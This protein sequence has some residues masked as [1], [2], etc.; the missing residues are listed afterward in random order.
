VADFSIGEFHV[1]RVEEWS[2]ALGSPDRLFVGFEPSTWAAHEADFAPAFYADGV[3]RGFL[4]SWLIEAKGQLI[5]LDTGVGNGKTRPSLPFFSDLDSDFLASFAKTGFAP[6]EVDIVVNSHLHMDHVGWNT[7][8]DLKGW[9]PTFPN[10]RYLVPALDLNFWNPVHWNERR[11]RGAEF[12]REAFED[13][14]Q[15]VLDKGLAELIGDAYEIAPGLTLTATPGHTPG[16]MMMEAESGG[17]HALFV[18]DVVHHPIQIYQPNWSTV[19]CEDTQLAAETRRKVL[20][21]AADR[22]ARI[23]PAHFAGRHWVGI[24]RDGQ[25]FCP[26]YESESSAS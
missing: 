14:I 2:G 8:R 25:N 18:A 17:E 1:H 20:G 16:Q 10:A 13:S 6:E 7:R 15:P 9:T 4:Q 19:F 11:P 22:G 23:V 26:I 3:C 24:E 5:L 21:L 12:N